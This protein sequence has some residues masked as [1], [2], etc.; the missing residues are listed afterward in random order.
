MPWAIFNRPSIQLGA[1]QGYLRE[2]G[3]DISAETL[4][5]YL[6]TA[7]TIGLDNYALLSENGWAGEALYASLLFPEQADRAATV[8]QRSLG[9][10]ATRDLPAF[11]LLRSQLD[12]QLDQ[13]LARLDLADCSLA[14]FSVC[15]SQLPASLLAARRL[16]RLF[17]DLPVV[18]GGSSCA[19]DISASLM[20]I[21]P[22]VDYIVTGEGEQSLLN[23]CRYLDGEA[24]EPGAG[25]AI[26]GRDGCVNSGAA[27]LQSPE[28]TDLDSL[29][30]P[31]FDDYFAELRHSGLN[32]IPALPVE[33]S[34]GCWWNKCT[35]CNLNLQWC[36]YRA[37][38]SSRMLS[39]IDHLRHRYRCLDFYFTDNSLPPAEAD[40]FFSVTRK[41]NA[42]LR[43]FG[44][45][46]PIPKASAYRLYHD[47]GLSSVQIGIEAFSGSLLTRMNKGVTVMDNIAAMK[48]CTESGIRLDGNL[49]V[50]F[51]G[52]T[53]EEVD[54]T[55]RTL[56]FVLPFRPL[57][58]AGF[59]LG[60][61]SPIWTDPQQFG[62]SSIQPHPFNRRLYPKHILARMPMLVEYGRG[63][64]RHQA[65][66]WQPVRKKITAWFQ[67]HH[68]RNNPT[69]PLIYREGGDFIIIRQERPE[70]Q[71]LHHRLHGISRKIY[72]AC[73]TPVTRK[74]LLHD[75]KSIT[76]KQLHV[77]LTD[78]E[79]KHL[80][81][82]DGEHYLALA[83]RQ[84]DIQ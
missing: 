49:I 1:L 50:E 22:E 27:L 37:K 76:E 74:T 25:T 41:N 51:P 57:K 5:P 69:P 62:I 61:G 64:R 32:F 60:H 34:R 26:R 2:H 83:V 43:F 18:F 33:F 56:D 63:E 44:E 30:V 4:H 38:T 81:F 9:R 71:V 53:P 40:R 54:E 16:K 29:P 70:M 19:P 6:E 59:F 15:F 12:S 42:D 72:L 55:L 28:A 75:F 77:F 14:G 82:S 48:H 68:R 79:R 78:L 84:R 73:R 58:A 7:K 13:W 24:E 45:I 21:F 52:S 66:I 31:V 3:G 23:L 67:F 46:R 11:D 36:G 10:T 20:E 80:V 35:F 8:F 65:K 39:E 17:P 47:G